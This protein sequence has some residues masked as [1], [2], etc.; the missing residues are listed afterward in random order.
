MAPPGEYSGPPG[1]AT[2]VAPNGGSAPATMGQSGTG[3]PVQADSIKTKKGT[4]LIP[5]WSYETITN[6]VDVEV[7]VW[8]VKKE[9]GSIMHPAFKL[10]PGRECKPKFMDRNLFHEVCVRKNRPGCR[11]VCKDK[12][13]SGRIGHTFRYKASDLGDFDPD[14]YDDP[15]KKLMPGA[16]KRVELYSY[17]IPTKKYKD[18]PYDNP[19]MFPKKKEDQPPTSDWEPALGD[20]DVRWAASVNRGNGVEYLTLGVFAWTFFML[21]LIGLKKVTRRNL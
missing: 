12:T 21:A 9:D 1:S 10:L 7:W 6:D 5:K 18:N 19:F 13:S 17:E 16:R 11:A 15:F 14:G 4:Y 2:N 20:P 8:W 3:M